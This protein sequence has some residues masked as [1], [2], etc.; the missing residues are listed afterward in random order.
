MELDAIARGIAR[1]WRLLAAIATVTAAV[2]TAVSP[3][4]V[5]VQVDYRDASYDVPLYQKLIAFVHRDLEMRGLATRLTEGVADPETRALR[6]FDWTSASIR[7]VPPGL[8]VVDD[9]PHDIV[10]RGYGTFDQAADV[11]A[12]LA[13]YAGIPAGMVF[14]RDVS[15]RP[16]YAFT[17]VE[18]GGAWR[19]F[20]VREHVAFRDPSGALASVDE[21]R[22]DPHRVAA[23]PPPREGNGRSYTEL[24]TALNLSEHRQV[25]DQMLL[26]RLWNELRR[27]IPLGR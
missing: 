15:G 20:D 2:A 26:V 17:I 3:S 12:N 14:S 21:L 25:G 1:R 6:L 8:P 24:I 5:S 13:A 7:P 9:H 4:R 19:L 11:Y 18:L 22:A 10:V 27:R 23:L 16:L